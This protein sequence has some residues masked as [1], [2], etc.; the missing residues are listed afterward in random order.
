MAKKEQKLSDFDDDP[1]REVLAGESDEGSEVLWAS[2]YEE[3]LFSP[4]K[5]ILVSLDLVLVVVMMAI[6]LVGLRKVVREEQNEVDLVVV[7]GLTL[8]GQSQ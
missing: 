4:L 5:V 3:W 7:V 1:G 6:L 2:F 8:Q